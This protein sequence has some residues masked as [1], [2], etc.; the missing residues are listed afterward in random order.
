MATQLGRLGEWFSYFGAL[1][2]TEEG[3]TQP[4]SGQLLN[5]VQRHPLGVCALISSFNHPLLISGTP[6]SLFGIGTILTDRLYLFSS[7]SQK[8]R[9]GIGSWQFRCVS[10]LP[11]LLHTKLIGSSSFSHPQAVGTRTAHRPRTRQNCQG[12]RS[13][14]LFL[15]LRLRLVQ[16]LLIVHTLQFPMACSPFCLVTA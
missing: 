7:F 10:P 15:Q 2:R 16:S 6:S 4:V 1:A 9:T 11:F 8:A 5:Y 12:S 13:F 14:V 3:T